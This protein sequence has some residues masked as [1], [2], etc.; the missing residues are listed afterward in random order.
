[1]LHV[2]GS[3]ADEVARTEL[4]GF[5][6]EL[7]E[8]S[9]GTDS[10][11][12]AFL[13]ENA[14]RGD[15]VVTNYAWE[16]L[17][18]HTRLPQGYKVLES[19]PIYRAA[20]EAGLPDY[21]FRP[22]AARWVVWRAAWEGYQGYE[23]RDVAARLAASGATLERVATVPESVFENRENLHFRRF[24]GLGYLYPRSVGRP[25][26]GLSAPAQIYRVRRGERSPTG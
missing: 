18:F 24:P 26:Y 23:W 3:L 5:A 16:P 10:G 25:A 17:Y 20:K 4:L 14:R 2:P 15:V 11:V 22:D 13:R 21:V 12:I 19:Y 9:P 1:V 6:R 8:S 7:V